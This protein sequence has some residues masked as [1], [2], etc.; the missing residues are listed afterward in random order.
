MIDCYSRRVVGIAIAHHMGTDLIMD[1][2]RMAIIHRNP[3]PGVISIR[4]RLC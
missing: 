4:V 1:A 3:P 2:L